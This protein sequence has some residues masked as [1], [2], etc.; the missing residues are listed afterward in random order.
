[1][2]GDAGRLAARVIDQHLVADGHRAHVKPREHAAHARPRLHL[3]A[4]EIVDAEGVGLRLHQPVARHG[5]PSSSTWS[6]RSRDASR[7]SS[8]N[9]VRL[10][11]NENCNL[12][13][14]GRKKS[15]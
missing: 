6:G 13:S 12:S 15:S 9:P 1:E 11:L 5:T 4:L 7:T 2:A 14:S 3:H 8:A 10:T